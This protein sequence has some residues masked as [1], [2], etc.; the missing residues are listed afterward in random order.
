MVGK[1]CLVTGATSGLGLATSLALAHKGAD[2]I[3][4]GRNPAKCERTVKK[5]KKSTGNDSIRPM[6]A[7]L[8]SQKDIHALADKFKKNYSSLDVL[9]NNAGAKFMERKETV[10]GLEMSFALNHL[11]YFLLTNLLLEALKNGQKAR[12][13]N[14]SSGAHSGCKNIDFENLQGEKNFDGR[15]A[16]ALSKLGNVL[17]TYELARRLSDTNITVNALSPGGVATHFSKNNGY[18]R[19]ARHIVS[20]LLTGNLVGPK[21]GAETIVY[22]AAS[23]K[24]EGITG[25]YFHNQKPVPSSDI[26]YDETLAKKLWDVSQ[27]LTEI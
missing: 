7:D 1:K 12:I 3:I 16:Y 20:H 11:G 22:L 17:F 5:I 18:M 4:V 2:V 13:V 9:V 24:A 8:S 23:P 14:V 10:D 27:K 25:K 15:A 6:I 26:S 19:W 21:K